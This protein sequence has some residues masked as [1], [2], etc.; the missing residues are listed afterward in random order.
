MKVSTKSALWGKL[1]TEEYDIQFRRVSGRTSWGKEVIDTICSISLI[2]K[3]T[4]KVKAA[5]YHFLAEG[6]AKQNSKDKFSKDRGRRISLGRAL[7]DRFVDTETMKEVDRFDKN[8]RDQIL[9]GYEH[10]G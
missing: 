5:K 8:T 1:Q 4:S 2:D 3:D 9:E 10:R 6:K 7:K